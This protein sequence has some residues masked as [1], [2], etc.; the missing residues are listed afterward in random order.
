ML[1]LN[2]RSEREALKAQQENLNEEL[3]FAVEH[4]KPGSLVTGTVAKSGPLNALRMPDM[5]IS[6]S[7][8]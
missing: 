2:Q 7:S 4:K 1:D 8:R 5:A 6:G 3:S